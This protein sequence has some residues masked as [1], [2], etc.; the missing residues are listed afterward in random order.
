MVWDLDGTLWDG[1]LIE[2]EDPAA[3]NLKLGIREIMAE[4]DKRGILQ[5]VASKNDEAAALAVLERLGIAEYF[6][7]PQIH[8]NPKSGSLGQIAKCLNIGIDALA[9]MASKMLPQ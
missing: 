2:T 5:S 1:T 9:F 4:L 8:W 3:L 7:Y 6:L